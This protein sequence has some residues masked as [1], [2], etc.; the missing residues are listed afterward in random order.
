M[1]V[2]VAGQ[3]LLA[4]LL[5]SLRIIAWLA[6]VPPFST[7]AVPAMAKVV[8]GLGLSFAVAPTLASSTIPVDT[9]GLLMVVLTQVLIGL[10]MGFLTSLLFSAVAAAGS[11]QV[12]GG[13]TLNGSNAA[14]RWLTGHPAGVRAS[15]GA[16]WAT[17]HAEAAA[18]TAEVA[19]VFMESPSNA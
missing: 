19:G 12:G 1:T 18:G 16:W 13:L 8:L 4:L 3:P 11:A 6:V 5:A 9:P 2:T 17:G 7:R 15:E 14:A 10:A